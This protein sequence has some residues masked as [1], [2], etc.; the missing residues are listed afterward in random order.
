MFYYLI[1]FIYL[2]FVFFQGEMVD[3]IENNIETARANVD[4]AV[5][6]TKK[7]A[8][9]QAAARRVSLI[10]YFIFIYFYFQKKIC[11]ITVGSVVGA[12]AAYYIGSKLGMF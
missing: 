7:A 3:R 1:L 5:S 2:L 10:V 6:D 9:Y 8:A 11:M 4:S 12:V